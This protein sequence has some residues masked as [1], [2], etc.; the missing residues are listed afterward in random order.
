MIVTKR[1]IFD[2]IDKRTVSKLMPLYRLKSHLQNADQPKEIYQN[3]ILKLQK[4]LQEP[5]L[6]DHLIFQPNPKEIQEGMTLFEPHGKKHKVKFLKSVFDVKD[7][8]DEKLPEVAFLGRSNVGKS[9]LLKC[10]FHSSPDLR[11]DVSRKPGRTK[12]LN[13]YEL[14]NTFRLIDM[15]GYGYNMPEHFV[16]SVEN[17]ISSR[18]NLTR[19]FLLIDSKVGILSADKIAFKMF[20]EFSIPYVIILTKIDKCRHHLLLKNLFSILKTQNQI[21]CFPQPFLISS[22]TGEGIPFLQTFIAY[23]TGNIAVNSLQR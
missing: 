7:L 6:E 5:I 4:Y 2:V 22:L 23:I 12:C 13:F 9:S 19:T 16:E 11:V 14:E 8:P 10:L 20:E 18:R 17:Y 3:P 21:I 1:F 15:P